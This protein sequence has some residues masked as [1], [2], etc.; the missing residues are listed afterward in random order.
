MRGCAVLLVLINLPGRSLKESTTLWIRLIEALMMSSISLI[1]A[2]IAVP[3]DDCSVSLDM[4]ASYL[5]LHPEETV[6]GLIL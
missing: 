1:Y 2:F 4:S 5:T 3:L 6:K